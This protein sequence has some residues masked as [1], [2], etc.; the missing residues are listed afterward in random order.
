MKFVATVGTE[1]DNEGVIEG[2]KWILNEVLKTKYA[3]A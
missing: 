3:A 1:Y 2:V